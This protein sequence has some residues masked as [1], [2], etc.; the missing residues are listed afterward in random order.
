M[1]K[2]R[3]YAFDR[4]FCF[5]NMPPPPPLANQDSGRRLMAVF[6]GRPAVWPVARQAWPLL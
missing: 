5:N 6:G 1:R 3:K 4:G 2:E